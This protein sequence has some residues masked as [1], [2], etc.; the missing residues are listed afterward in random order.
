[1][2]ARTPTEEDTVALGARL[3][4]ALPLDTPGFVVTQLHGDL[5]AGKTTLVRGFLE[6]LG[7]TGPVRSPTYTLVEV[8][9][10]PM[11]GQQGLTCVHLDLY[12]LAEP[13]ELE[14]LGLS[15]WALPRHLWLI[16]WPEKG[17]DL[18]PPADLHI[19]LTACADAHQIVI[20]AATPQGES[21]I[22]RMQ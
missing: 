20:N 3:A 12:R 17:G 2:Q 22:E 10:L 6:A 15:E 7:V 21:W 5:G 9:E 18:L 8:Y 16:E 11:H 14:P 4:R 19:T 13:S 1:M